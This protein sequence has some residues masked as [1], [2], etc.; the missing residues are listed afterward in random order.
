[1]AE[2]EGVVAEGSR[3]NFRGRWAEAR[4]SR[5]EPGT[6]KL[7]LCRLDPRHLLSKSPC[8]FNA[9]SKSLSLL[10]IQGQLLGSVYSKCHYD[11]HSMVRWADT[12]SIKAG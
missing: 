5:W 12:R 10:P 7:S 3:I 6:G 9:F 1:M 11:P 8:R 4:A 2:Y